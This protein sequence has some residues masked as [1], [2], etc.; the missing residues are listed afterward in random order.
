MFQFE[1]LRHSG[2]YAPHTYTLKTPI[3]H[4]Q[5]LNIYEFRVFLRIN[6][7]YVLNNPCKNAT[8]HKDIGKTHSEVT[9]GCRG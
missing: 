2:Y 8:R 9:R 1:S 3:F 5:C 7:D 4:P 6:A